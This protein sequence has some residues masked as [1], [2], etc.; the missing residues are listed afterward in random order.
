[1]LN[2]LPTFDDVADAYTRLRTWVADT[3]VLES[4][5]LNELA[6][7]RVLCKAECLQHSGSFKIRGALNL[8]LRLAVAERAAGV[9]AFSSGNHAQG[10]ALAAHWLRI[11]ATI[12]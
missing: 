11:P 2:V 1:M 3:P 12:V 5:V 9:V 4:A 7:T 10:V 8:L 6:G